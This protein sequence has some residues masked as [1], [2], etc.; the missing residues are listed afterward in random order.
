M[1]SF[2]LHLL[3]IALFALP[4]GGICLKAQPAADS[5]ASVR[6]FSFFGVPL[7]FYSPDTRWGGGAAGIFTF[8]GNPLRSSITF[9]F[10]YTQRRQVL[11]WI[12]FQWYHR[13][14][15]WRAYGELGWYRYLYQYFGIGN[16]YADDFLETYTARF[17]R[18][19]S[20]VARR[21]QNTRHFFG[22]RYNLDDYHISDVQPDGDLAV[23]K[24][25]GARGGFSSSPGLVWL[26]DSRDSPFFPS[27][28][29]LT[30][31]SFV[32]ENRFSGSDFQYVRWTGE[33]S[34]YQKAGRNIL[35]VNAMAVFSTAGAP[36]F[37]M[38]QLG[39][40]RRLRGYP[41]G[42]FRDKHLLLLQAEGRIPLFW[43]L[44]AVAFGGVGSVFGTSGEALR[45]RSNL[46][47]GLRFEFDKKQH[48]NVRLDYGFGI[49][50]KHSGAYLTVGEAF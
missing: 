10:A 19:R 21:W 3:L 36:F 34:A 30:E 42:R 37:L 1:K 15:N 2:L 47:G 17:P 24:I 49:G 28:G 45:L 35:A 16:E 12:P 22:L 39:G 7:A 20:T 8:P 43:R 5:S 25:P 18:V 11:A 27:K 44:K 40:T 4:T 13:N 50:T 41:D 31:S 48:I 26:Y 46:G 33:V 14:G 32:F 23:G 38:P 6:K 29:I 9:S